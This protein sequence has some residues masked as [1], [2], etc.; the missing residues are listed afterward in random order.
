[1]APGTF[2]SNTLNSLKLM[3]IPFSVFL[4]PVYWFALSR[5]PAPDTGKAIL[6]FIILHLL[7]YPA[8]NGYNSYFDRDEGSIGGLKNPP[9]VTPGLF[10]M[11]VLFDLL[12]VLFSLLISPLFAAMVLVYLLVSKAYSYDKIRLKKYPLSSTAVVVVFQGAFVFLTVQAG[13]WGDMEQVMEKQN[14][15]FALVSSLFLL[16]SYPLTQ[17]YQ[18]KEDIERGDHTLSSRLGIWGT[19]IFSG[20]AFI[21]A[22]ALLARLYL[23]NGQETSLLIYFASTLPIILFFGYWILQVKRSA[24]AVNFE[25]TMRLNAIS[26]LGLSICFIAILIWG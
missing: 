15:L 21:L 16:G 2:N 14:L 8:S 7:V 6:V 3:R 19:F 11:V 9:K 13:I 24:E 20:I 4:M 23:K 12:A 18:H 22:T 1:M 5:T 26:S 25:N 10:K 17:I